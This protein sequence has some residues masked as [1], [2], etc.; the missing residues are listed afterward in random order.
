MSQPQAL[1][2]PTGVSVAAPV[3]Q[4]DPAQI[5][6]AAV[7]PLPQQ[8]Q[9]VDQT[10]SVPQPPA[11]PGMPAAVVPGVAA[12]VANPLPGMPA[13]AMAPAPAPTATPVAPNVQAAL[14]GYQQS[15]AVPANYT[16]PAAF[17]PFGI[18]LTD[19]KSGYTLMEKGVI[20]VARIKSLKPDLSS[21]NNHMLKAELDVVSQPYVGVTVLD[22]LTFS[23]KSLWK[24]KSLCSATGAWDQNNRRYTLQ[25]EQQ[26]VGMLVMFKVGHQPDQQDSTKF[27]NA[28]D[29]GYMAYVAPQ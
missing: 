11:M 22:N 27:Y 16:P 24:W 21:N 18:D 6:V 23:E 15:A 7:Q 26:L 17:N 5:A 3:A 20:V 2:P 25:S 29:G 19:V 28:V 12:P 1:V 4:P 9:G 14:Q 10:T 13:P 8:I